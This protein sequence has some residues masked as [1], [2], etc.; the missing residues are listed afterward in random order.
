MFFQSYPRNISTTSRSHNPTCGSRL[1]G[2]R[3]KFKTVYGHLNSKYTFVSVQKE[4]ISVVRFL[5]SISR[6]Q[7]LYIAC[8]AAFFRTSA[9]GSS[10][11]VGFPLKCLIVNDAVGCCTSQGCWALT[12]N[13]AVSK[14][15]H[16]TVAKPAMDLVA[17]IVVI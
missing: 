12:P 10:V 4:R 15:L 9:A 16:T 1:F 6:L 2:G 11:S 8:E 14:Q 3:N 13:E 5:Y 7:S 17:R